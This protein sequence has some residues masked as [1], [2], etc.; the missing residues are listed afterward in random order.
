LQ[1]YSIFIEIS[2]MKQTNPSSTLRVTVSLGIL[3]LNE[4]FVQLNEI[5]DWLIDFLLGIFIVI[6]IY[7]NT[8]G[9]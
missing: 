1:E 7:E 3:G 5:M 8:T 9:N 4:S 2:E 6:N